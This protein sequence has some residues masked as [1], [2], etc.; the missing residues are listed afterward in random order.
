[1][2][3]LHYFS[4]QLRKCTR[5]MNIFQLIEIKSTRAFKNGVKQGCH[6]SPLLFSLY[7]NDMGRDIS[8]GI[9][10]AATG[11]GVNGVSYMLCADD[12][13]LTSNDP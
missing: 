9:R 1:M 7:I 4:G 5:M 11:E 10:G 12:L 6:L 2:E 8:E 3:C 13:S